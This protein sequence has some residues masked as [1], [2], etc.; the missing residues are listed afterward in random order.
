MNHERSCPFLRTAPWEEEGYFSTIAQ[1]FLT[2]KFYQLR[3]LSPDFQ[4][5]T[6]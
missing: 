4:S 3:F 2:E 6:L 1:V 5:R